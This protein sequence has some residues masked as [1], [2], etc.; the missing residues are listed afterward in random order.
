MLHKKGAT[1]VNDPEETPTV[2]T[3]EAIPRRTHVGRWLLET[4]V[5]V[6]LAFLVAQGVKTFIVQPFVIP[7]A[8]MQPAIMAGDRVLAEKLSVRFRD[9]AQGEVVVF[10]DPT[11]R[12]PQLIKRVIAVGGQTVDIRDG[13]VIVDGVVL[14]EPYVRGVSTEAGTASLPHTLAHDEVWLMGDN[15]PN[16]GDSRV[17]GPIPESMVRGRAF[18]IYWPLGRVGGL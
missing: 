5:M 3:A 7:T 9:P 15:R 6:A 13:E 2:D 10:D 4:A 18:A 16:S 11:G 8:S 12:H 17:L 14:S 1:Q